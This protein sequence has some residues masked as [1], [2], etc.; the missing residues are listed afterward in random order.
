[1]IIVE[2]L[3]S[4]TQNVFRDRGNVRSDDQSES[5]HVDISPN[6]FRKALAFQPNSALGS[7]RW[8][9]VSPKHVAPLVERLLQ[10]ITLFRTAVSI[11]EQT[12]NIPSICTR[13]GTA[14]LKGLTM[15]VRTD[16]LIPGS[17]RCNSWPMR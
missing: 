10:L 6:V 14:L 3:L 13:N 16:V 4:L 7:I 1:M 5:L 15:A 17:A 9:F 2:D 8:D 12:T 11:L